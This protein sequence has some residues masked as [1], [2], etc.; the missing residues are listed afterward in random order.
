MLRVIKHMPC[1]PNRILDAAQVGHG[2][3][4]QRFAVDDEGVERGLAG[5]IGRAA[6]ADGVVALIVLACLAAGLDGVESVGGVGE[7]E[8]GGVGG[9]GEGAGPGVDYEGERG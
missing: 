6:E 3:G 9:G 7:G 5:F 4:V 8:E 2:A 1:H